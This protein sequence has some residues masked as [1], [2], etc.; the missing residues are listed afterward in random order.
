MLKRVIGIEDESDFAIDEG[1]SGDDGNDLLRG[2]SG[3]DFLAGGNVDMWTEILLENREALMGP[4]Q[5]TIDDLIQFMRILDAQDQEA[6]RQWLE[7]AKD[8][9]DS[10]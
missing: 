8:R 2:G 3:K 6:A 7:A 4:V 10:L 1:S 5:R 9:R